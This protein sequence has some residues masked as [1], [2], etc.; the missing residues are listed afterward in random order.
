MEGE[1]IVVSI[2]SV[3]GMIVFLQLS[4]YNY[5]K[6]KTFLHRLGQQKKIDK[7]K[8]SKMERELGLKTSRSKTEETEDKGLIGL[9]KGLDKDKI[10]NIL[11]MLQGEEE[12]EDE[13]DW[14]KNISPELI[15]SVVKGMNKNKSDED[16]TQG[17]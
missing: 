2:I 4:Q 12:E 9:L 17:W 5:F 16:N 14:I 11:E 8:L 13:M 6:K 7:L 10:G 15:N 3:C 1:L